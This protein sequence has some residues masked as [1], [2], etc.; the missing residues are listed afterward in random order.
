MPKGET[1]VRSCDHCTINNSSGGLVGLTCGTAGS[2]IKNSGD[3][4]DALHRRFLLQLGSAVGPE[5][6]Q[7]LWTERQKSQR[8]SV[9]ELESVLLVIVAPHQVSSEVV[10]LTYNNTEAMSY[11]SK[12]GGTKSFKLTQ[13]V[14]KILKICDDWKEIWLVSVHLPGARNIQGDALLRV[15]LTIPSGWAIRKELLPVFVKWGTLVI[16]L[17]VTFSNSKLLM[18]TSLFPNPRT[19]Y[20]VSPV[21]RDGNDV[22]LPTIQD[23]PGCAQQN[24]QIPWSD[25]DL[26][27]HVDVRPAGNFSVRSHFYRAGRSAPLDTRDEPSQGRCWY[28]SLPTLKFTC[29]ATLTALLVKKWHSPHPGEFM[30]NCQKPSSQQIYET[31][32]KKFVQHLS[33]SIGMCLAYVAFISLHMFNQGYIPSTTI[34]IYST[35]I[36]PILKHWK[37]NSAM[38]PEIRMIQFSGSRDMKVVSQLPTGYGSWNHNFFLQFPTGYG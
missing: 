2:L 5:T 19:K 34:F 35:S 32:W 25:S 6:L 8:I 20:N 7:R 22:C 21:V 38:D 9:I 29:L 26:S 13:F 12:E 10:R 31:H 27:G 16:D 14:I 33:E 17:L 28:T 15:G 18:Y 3:W 36:T 24:P 4:G 37:C 30:T 1:V 23:A 11:I